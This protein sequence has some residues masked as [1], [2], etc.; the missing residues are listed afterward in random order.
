MRVLNPR[1]VGSVRAGAWGPGSETPKRT[2]PGPL[3]EL[4]DSG[5]G[6]GISTGS[7]HR[8]PGVVAG[9]GNQVPQL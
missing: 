5:Q 9:G 8:P 6:V 1:S 2:A 7:G 4:A 3:I